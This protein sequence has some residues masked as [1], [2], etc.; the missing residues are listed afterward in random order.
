MRDAECIVHISV[1]AV[2]QLLDEGLIVPLL[3][4]VEPEVLEELDLWGQLCQLLANRAELPPLV[5]R[6]LGPPEV[7]ARS[8]MGPPLDQVLKGGQ[9]GTDPEV[10]DHRRGLT[11]AGAQ[12]DVEVDPDQ[13]AAPLQD[14]EI[15]EQWQPLQQ[16][17]LLMITHRH[18][19]PRLPSTFPRNPL[20]F[21]QEPAPISSERSTSLFEYPHSLSYQPWTLTRVIPE[22]D[23]ITMVKPASNVHEAGLP[24]MSD[25]TMGSSV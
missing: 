1:V 14:R 18:S 9:R 12:G 25:D 13:N 17:I 19:S 6:P 4:R 24:T 15:G 7:G 16:R 21:P 22:A 2:D 11:G 3:A 5:R 8:H 20:T 23:G 10:V